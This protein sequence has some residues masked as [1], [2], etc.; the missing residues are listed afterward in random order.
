MTFTSA[1]VTGG[2]GFVGSALA[3]ALVRSG[4]R[5]S[6]LAR[7]AA[8]V[9]AECEAIFIEG[10]SRDAISP[11]LTGRRFDV[12][13]HLAAYGVAP[14]DR[15]PAQTFG[16]NIAGTDAVVHAAAQTGAGVVVY[17]GSCSEYR[18]PVPGQRIDEV[19]VLG[20]NRLYGGSKAA[21]GLWGQ[22]LAADRGVSF[23]WLRLFNVFGPGEASWRLIPALLGKLRAGEPVALSRGD[24]VRDY[25]YVDDAVAGIRLAAD[26]ALEGKAGPFNLCSGAPITVKDIALSVADALGR[27]YELLKFGALDYR[28]D[29][30]V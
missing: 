2:T 4:I 16:A 11:V 17:V 1:L 22:A 20:P 12:V 21:A 5:T 8:K 30:V 27:P 15:D 6:L 19:A 10:L 24:Q 18:S 28:P 7:P 9:P 13:F 25:L 26:A 23:Q 3:C 29:D 14:S